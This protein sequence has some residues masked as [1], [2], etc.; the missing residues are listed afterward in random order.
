M[1]MAIIYA[2]LIVIIILG[3]CAIVYVNYYNKMQYAKTKIE[4]AESIIDETLRE[5]YDTIGKAKDYIASFLNT[6]KDYFKHYEDLKEKNISN[7][8]LDRKL[9]EY[10]RLIYQLRNDHEDLEEDKTFK[11]MVRTLKEADEKLSAAKGFYNKYTTELN[12]YARKFPS[13]FVAKLHGIAVS[14]F[15]DGKDMT[16]DIIDDFKL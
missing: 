9:A 12:N 2:L 14:P 5:K 11:D 10:D 15:F 13:N 1:V 6:N 16:D 4:Q 8:D 7:F 3:S